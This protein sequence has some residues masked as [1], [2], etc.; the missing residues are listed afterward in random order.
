MWV[1]HSMDEDTSISTDITAYSAQ[2][3]ALDIQPPFMNGDTNVAGVI[4]SELRLKDACST[5]SVV[6]QFWEEHTGSHPLRAGIV[7]KELPYKN[8][9]AYC[10]A[11]EVWGGHS[12]ETRWCTPPNRQIGLRDSVQ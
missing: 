2:R 5:L 3:D 6:S 8:E 12:W 7:E 9:S 10:Q 11:T 4:V 1:A